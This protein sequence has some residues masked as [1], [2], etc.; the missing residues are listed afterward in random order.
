MGVQ[1]GSVEEHHLL[2]FQHQA[3][4]EES[5]TTE[6]IPLILKFLTKSVFLFSKEHYYF[7]FFLFFGFLTQGYPG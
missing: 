3:V 5:L 4:F 6:F 7:T 2:E 1:K